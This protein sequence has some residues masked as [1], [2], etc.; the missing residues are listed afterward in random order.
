MQPAKTRLRKP[1]K[2]ITYFLQ[3]QEAA[4]E[5]NQL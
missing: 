3:K 2:A 1:Y 5:K 4:V